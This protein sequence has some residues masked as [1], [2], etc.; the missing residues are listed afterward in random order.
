MTG[1]AAIYAR[2]SSDLQSPHS[3]EDQLRLCREFAAGRALEIVECYSDAAISGAAI[4]NRPAVC[5]LIEDAKAGRF[6]VVIA[7]ALDRLSRDQ[8]D[9]AGL[10][11]RL[12]HAGVRIVTLS[13]G[14]ISELHVGLKGTMNA[15]FLKDLAAKVR[16]G[17]RGRV[18]A[19]RAGGGGIGYGYRVVRRLGADGEPERG[20]REIDPEQAEVVRRIFAEYLAGRS[21]RA[22]AAGLNA[23]GIPS[24]RG[25]IWAANA[26]NGNAARGNGVLH[27][28][29]Y[30][31][32]LIYNRQTFRKDPDTGR[33]VPRVNPPE[34]WIRVEVPALRIIDDATWAAVQRQRR[35]YTRQAPHQ[36]RRP[37][38]LLSGL[39]RCGRC[40]GPVTVVAA[41]QVG[42]ARHRESGT[43]GNHR[44]VTIA[45]LEPAV[46]EGIRDH[47]LDPQHV[48]DYVRKRQ[49]LAAAE[50]AN[51]G[52][53][54]ATHR[55]RLDRLTG[56]IRRAVAAIL[57][58]TDS[59]EL[60]QQLRQMEGEKADLEQA[61]KAAEP[62]P[63]VTLHPGL[64]D[65]Y[66]DSVAR[67]REALADPKHRAEA[68]LI[69]RELIE[70]I[71][72][73]HGERRGDVEIELTGQLQALAYAAEPT[74]AP[75]QIVN[76]RMITM[77]APDGFEPPTK[78]L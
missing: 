15:L 76:A 68:V 36:A 56:Q 37:K 38:H 53:T 12:S 31:G 24:P 58:G 25:G 22:I 20:L 26:I 78:G 74:A 7:E 21:P 1:R 49:A 73:H 67:L 23:D 70:G 18:E 14:E 60:R 41:G 55:K 29:S 3:I 16:R 5:R 43:C 11:K 30:L 42:C 34:Q 13:E 59:P 65:Q 48:A 51:A 40:G 50:R 75:A 35:G 66:R 10:Y 71:A 69:L 39:L 6:A 46:F 44:R 8:E 52:R 2:Y 47:L 63:V 19:G 57:D 9:I 28:E 45:R 64:A 33:R 77:V 17:Q 61:L 4:L 62:A 32:R 27:N 54:E 72:I